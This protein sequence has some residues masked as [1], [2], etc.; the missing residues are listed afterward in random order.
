MGKVIV[1]MLYMPYYLYLDSNL[2]LEGKHSIQS[3]SG[4]FFF[5]LGL[6]TH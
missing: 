6:R 1:E 2:Y 3:S 5:L 4:L